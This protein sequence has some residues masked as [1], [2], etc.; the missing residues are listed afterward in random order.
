M[1]DTLL[2]SLCPVARLSVS[3]SRAQTTNE[4]GAGRPRLTPLARRIPGKQ[5][6]RGSAGHPANRTMKRG[7][8]VVPVVACDCLGLDLMEVGRFLGSESFRPMRVKIVNFIYSP[9]NTSD[10]LRIF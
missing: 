10:K 1:T 8:R 3:L 7:L 6:G 4:H 9:I 5:Y 2:T